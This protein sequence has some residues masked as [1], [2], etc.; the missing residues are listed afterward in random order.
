[1]IAFAAAFVL[2]VEPEEVAMTATAAVTATAFA[3]LVP[4][5]VVVGAYVMVA[6]Y[7]A[8]V[9]YVVS[10]FAAA[11]VASPLEVSEFLVGSACLELRPGEG[12]GENVLD[13]VTASGFLS[14]E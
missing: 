12:Y 11:L 10:A 1:M 9:E 13:K 2:A 3:V 6:A 7:I 4:A 8:A 14:V 5:A